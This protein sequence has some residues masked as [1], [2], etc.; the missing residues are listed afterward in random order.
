MLA[1][2]PFVLG[3]DGGCGSRVGLGDDVCIEAGVAH[4]VGEQFMGGPGGCRPCLCNTGG[5]VLCDPEPCEEPE[6]APCPY[7]GALV[8]SGQ[9]FVAADGCNVCRCDEPGLVVCSEVSPDVGC[10]SSCEAHGVYFFPGEIVV[11]SEGCTCACSAS[12]GSL[13][14]AGPTCGEGCIHGGELRALGS[15]FPTT[16]GPCECRTCQCQA[17]GQVHCEPALCPEPGD[18]FLPLTEPP[19][20]PAGQL[21]LCQ[22]GAERTTRSCLACTI[23]HE[24]GPS[25][26][27]VTTTCG[28]HEVHAECTSSTCECSRDGVPVGSCTLS[29]GDRCEAGACC[30]VLAFEP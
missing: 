7:E 17:E 15:I 4:A 26:C 3:A 11:E 27:S 28:S 30:A 29:N 6:A 8:A 2:A 19:E 24:E 20:V 10:P 18:T 21:A 23:A 9:T 1:A 16:Q 12:S 5:A 25:G 22:C 14:C 13:V